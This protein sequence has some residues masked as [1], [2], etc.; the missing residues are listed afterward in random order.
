MFHIVFKKELLKSS[1]LFFTLSRKQN[2]HKVNNPNQ[3]SLF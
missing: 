3:L 2:Y 1:F